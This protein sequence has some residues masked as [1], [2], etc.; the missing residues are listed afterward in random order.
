M[1]GEY[2]DSRLGRIEDPFIFKRAGQ[3][4]LHAPRALARVNM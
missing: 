1:K 2:L 4:T 3:L